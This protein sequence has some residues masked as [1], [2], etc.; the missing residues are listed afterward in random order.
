[1][2]KGT[3]LSVGN[4][5]PPLS[6]LFCVVSFAVDSVA[7]SCGLSLPAFNK[8]VWPMLSFGHTLSSRRVFPLAC[9]GTAC[10]GQAAAPA[11]HVDY[12]TRSCGLSLPALFKRIGTI[13]TDGQPANT[14]PTTIASG[15][16]ERHDNW[17][18]MTL[19]KPFSRPVTHRPI[20]RESI[21]ARAGPLHSTPSKQSKQLGATGECMR[22]QSA[23]K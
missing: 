22:S 5:K 21:S 3:K 19:A 16:A 12:L 6:L 9:A 23:P 20:E 7:Q 10:R 4:A 1:M 8:G 13:A 14:T 2:S 15:P 17:I 18:R 11:K